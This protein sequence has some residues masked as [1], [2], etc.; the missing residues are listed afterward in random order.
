MCS[1][2][3]EEIYQRYFAAGPKGDLGRSPDVLGHNMVPMFEDPEMTLALGSFTTFV[4]VS[5]N[6]QT[7]EGCG[8]T[9]LLRGAHHAVEKF[10]RWQRDTNNHLGPEAQAGPASATRHPAAAASSTCPSP[11]ASSSSTRPPSPRPT[12][13]GGRGRPRS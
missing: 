9:A 7:K 1:R 11:C 4:F 3:P 12:E 5:L 10:L 2:A 8:Q 13:E 6:D